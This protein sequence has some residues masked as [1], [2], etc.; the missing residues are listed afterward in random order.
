MSATKSRSEKL[1]ERCE[2]VAPGVLI[3]KNAAAEGRGRTIE[4]ILKAEADELQEIS[5]D[6][7]PD[8]CITIFYHISFFLESD[9]DDKKPF[10][11]TV[12]SRYYRLN[13]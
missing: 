8:S 11:T 3:E 9:F 5:E 6:I 2:Q 13:K 4:Q 10:D 7:I 1:R 12:S